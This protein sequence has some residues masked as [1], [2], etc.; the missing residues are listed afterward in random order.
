MKLPYGAVLALLCL[1][2]V[3]FSSMCAQ[4]K[5][6][7]IATYLPCAEELGGWVLSDSARIFAG[8][9]LFTLIDGGA[10]L[11]FEYGFRQVVS[12]EYR[13]DKE[14]SIKLELYEMSDDGAA[15]GRY[16]LVAGSQG[17]KVQIGNEGLLNEYYL[18]FWK[19]RFL[20][21]LSASDTARE[22]SD[23][24]LAIATILDRNIGENGKEPPLLSY[25][26]AVGLKARTYVR[27]NIGLLS[28]YTFDTKNDFGMRAG[29]IG[30]YSSY[31][32]FIFKYDSAGEAEENFKNAERQLSAGK[33]FSDFTISTGHWTAKD[34]H[35]LQLYATQFHNLIIIITTDQR[36]NPSAICDRV[37]SFILTIDNRRN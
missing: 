29:V 21:F 1:S 6:S 19:S 20:V 25:L 7:A 16:S 36:N 5:I 2:V 27:G 14:Q 26:P 35:G 34:P 12:A 18:V 30:N 9:E 28:V 11:Y 3:A 33:R 17:M 32:V 4:A 10:D 24:I 31:A 15:F 13:N 8:E 23:E 22:I 37:I